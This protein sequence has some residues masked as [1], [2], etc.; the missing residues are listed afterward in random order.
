MALKRYLSPKFLSRKAIELLVRVAF[1]SRIELK[2]SV[3]IVLVTFIL[4][5]YGGWISTDDGVDSIV[6]ELN[7]YLEETSRT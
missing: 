2:V 5:L 4:F 1:S 7:R 3:Y 6:D